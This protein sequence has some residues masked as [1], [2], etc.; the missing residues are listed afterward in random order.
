[1]NYKTI[2]SLFLGAAMLVGCSGNHEEYRGRK[3][4]TEQSNTLTGKVVAV[5][6]GRQDSTRHTIVLEDG[7]CASAKSHTQGRR[8]TD[9]FALATAAKEQGWIIT[10]TGEEYNKDTGCLVY[11]K[12]TVD[13]N[14]YE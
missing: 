3:V 13:T 7:S 9:N 2:G 5:E 4:E 6:F 14:T 12:L 1:M 11:E 8:N 10:L